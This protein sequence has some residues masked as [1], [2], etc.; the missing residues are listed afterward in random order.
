[1]GP[2][3]G[4]DSGSV[5]T[6]S[7][8]RAISPSPNGV[9]CWWGCG[10][11]AGPGG[12]VGPSSAQPRARSCRPGVRPTGSHP[13][14][15]SSTTASE[16]DPSP[17][18]PRATPCPQK[19]PGSTP[20][21][22]TFRGQYTGGCQQR[23]VHGAE[24]GCPRVGVPGRAHAGFWQG[25]GTRRGCR[26]PPQHPEK[27]R[28]PRG[29]PG[30]TGARH[31]Q[32]SDPGSSPQPLLGFTNGP[33]ND[34]NSLTRGLGMG[35]TPVPLG[36]TPLPWGALLAAGCSRWRPRSSGNVSPALSFS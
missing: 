11:R 10:N 19:S 14:S 28:A 6:R 4:W 16:S 34:F 1:M 3:W 30:A 31:H 5:G 21:V 15:L 32:V 17:A 8:L 18:G 29:A 20:G 24:G 9:G 27:S 2:H 23:S 26:G 25:R 33:A 7:S 36:W 12:P 22:V 35:L 13:A